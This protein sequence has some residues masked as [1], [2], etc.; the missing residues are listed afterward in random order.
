MAQFGALLPRLKQ[1]GYTPISF[2][3]EDGWVGDA[4]YLTLLNAQ[5][6]PTALQ[7]ALRDAATFSFATAPFA[8]AATTLQGWAKSGYFSKQFGGLDP[9]DAVEAFFDTGHTAMQ[10]ISSTEASQ[11]LASWRDDDS[12]AKQVGVFAFPSARAGEPPVI[13]Q[14]GYSGWAIP[15]AAHSAAAALDFIDFAL[16]TPTAQTLL[17][18]GLI[19]VRTVTSGSSKTAAPFQ[20]DFLEALAH[21]TPGVYVDAAP[22]PNFLATMEA[23]VQLLLAG[24]V[25]PKALTQSLQQTYASHGSKTQYTDT[26]GEF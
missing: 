1:A 9:Q 8:Q 10:L 22:V 17:A 19:P 21:A 14:D 7:P 13:V 3:D 11:V 26:D 5:V 6:G 4:W 18:Q 15:R 16:S 20:Q 25:T 2:G 24:K 23:Q 12:K